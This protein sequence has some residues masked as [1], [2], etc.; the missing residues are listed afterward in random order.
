M[1]I[2][3]Y[4]SQRRRDLNM[5]NKTKQNK[6]KTEHRLPWMTM[7]DKRGQKHM[8]VKH[9]HTM[10]PCFFLSAKV[11]QTGTRQEES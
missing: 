1:D 6:T 11:L 7:D 9:M 3:G 8:E 4:D 2:E 10:P 5:K